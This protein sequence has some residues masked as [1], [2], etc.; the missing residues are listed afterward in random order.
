MS[1][2][3][4]L[5]DPDP[6]GQI[7]PDDKDWTWVLQRPCPECGFDASTVPPTAVAD[8]LRANVEQWQRHLAAPAD[9]LR[10]RPRP[11]RWSTLEYAVHVRDVCRRYDQRLTLMLQ[12]DDPLF[13]NW[14]QDVSAVEDRYNEQ[15]PTVVAADLAEDGERL[16]A[17]FERVGD[18]QWQRPGRRSDGAHFTIDSFARYFIH[19]PIH[20]LWDVDTARAVQS[21]A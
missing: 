8:L 9:D 1:D 20:H 7:A 2:T 12:T 21:E 5:D 18:D 14:D 3:A 16:A 4:H 17:A 6:I 11:D 15:D 10:R 19:D 13:E